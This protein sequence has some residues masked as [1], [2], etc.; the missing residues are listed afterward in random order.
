MAAVRGLSNFE[1]RASLRTWVIGIVFNL[2]RRQGTREHRNVPDAS[3]TMGPT[4]DPERFQGPDGRYPGGWRQFPSPWPSPEDTA[5]GHEITNQIYAALQKLPARQREVVELR[6]V[7]GF[8]SGEVAEILELTPGNER[9][10]LH[11]G[12][13]AIRRELESYFSDMVG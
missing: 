7:Q 2:A 12:R 6:D 5:V 4:V 3:L 1:G 13:A 9:I 8:D 11:R 10:L